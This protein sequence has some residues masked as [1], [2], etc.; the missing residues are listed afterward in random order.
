[1]RAFLLGKYAS[2]VSL[3][4]SICTVQVPL[5]L[6]AIYGGGVFFFALSCL[7]LLLKPLCCLLLPLYFI[8]GIENSALKGERLF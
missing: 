4:S 3:A 8:A 1:M 5:S 7:F 2:N 6:E